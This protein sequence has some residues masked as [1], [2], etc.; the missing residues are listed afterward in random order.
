V[1]LLERDNPYSVYKRK[2]ARGQTS[3]R[4]NIYLLETTA[5]T[6]SITPSISVK[7]KPSPHQ[8]PRRDLRFPLAAPPFPQPPQAP[9]LHAARNAATW[10]QRYKLL[11]KANFETGFALYRLQKGLKPDAFKLWVN[12]IRELVQPHLARALL[13]LVR[14]DAVHALVVGTSCF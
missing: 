7:G 6:K 8:S 4:N 5:N 3:S 11:S 1:I 14:D 2:I 12:W 13:G 10:L 9:P